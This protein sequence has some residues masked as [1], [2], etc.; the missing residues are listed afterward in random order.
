MIDRFEAWFLKHILRIRD[1]MDD[2]N[3]EP[4]KAEEIPWDVPLDQTTGKIYI[5]GVGEFPVERDRA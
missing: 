4:I 2:P 3:W 1:P 5:L